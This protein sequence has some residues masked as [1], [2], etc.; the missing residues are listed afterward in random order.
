MKATVT[1]Q[2]LSRGLA[3]V[4]PAIARRPT[5]PVLSHVLID[6]LNTETGIRL[7]ASDLETRIEAT[8]EAQVEQ[9]GQVTVPARLLADLVKAY[10]DGDL[11]LEIVEG[12]LHL[13]ADH[14]RATLR[15]IPADEFPM[16]TVVKGR[17]MTFHP[18][19]LG[20]A[21]RNV[22]FAAATEEVR[23]VLTGVLFE[24]QGNTLSLAA[25][26]GFRLAV[27][28]VTL[29]EEIE[30]PTKAILPAATL[31]Q[32]LGPLAEEGDPVDLTLGTNS[33][34]FSLTG[35]AGANEERVGDIDFS[36]QLIEGQYVNYRQ[37]IPTRHA[38][39]VM[40][41]TGELVRACRTARIFA[42]SDDDVIRLAVHPSDNGASLVVQAESAE[43]GQYQVE[44]P[45]VGEGDGMQFGINVRFFLDALNTIGTARTVLD[46]NSDKQ[47]VVVKPEGADYPVHVIMPMYISGKDKSP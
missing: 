35:Y 44:L 37:I 4:S 40:V 39:Q 13:A 34:C 46:L 45:I 6:G 25:A 2:A 22:A 41:D 7:I 19:V 17:T 21:I 14:N 12:D 36:T 8:V 15:G 1:R 30:N 32:L 23:P 10:P 47:P 26:D 16:P 33:A 27:H 38:T 43:L 20:A 31:K 9:P 3:T 42:R 11:A 24:A 29:E 28:Q 18:T 5:L